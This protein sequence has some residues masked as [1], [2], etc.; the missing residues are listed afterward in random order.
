MHLVF[1][2]RNK[3]ASV[4]LISVQKLRQQLAE[5]SL[6]PWQGLCAVPC[7]GLASSACWLHPSLTGGQGTT[8]WASFQGG[9]VGGLEGGAGGPGSWGTMHCLPSECG[10][11][12]RPGQHHGQAR[13][14]GAGGMRP[15][16]LGHLPPAG[17]QA[18]GCCRGNC[19]HREG[20]MLAAIVRASLSA[21]LPS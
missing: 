11:S 1:T 2:A 8:L 7:Q 14:R 15:S 19:V 3:A 9:G 12:A 17:L 6:A 4:S 20:F 5:T 10:Q 18:E 21:F 16:P 13:P